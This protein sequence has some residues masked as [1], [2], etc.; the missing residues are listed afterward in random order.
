[1]ATCPPG[2]CE[3]PSGGGGVRSWQINARTCYACE[4]CQPLDPAWRG[5]ASPADAATPTLFPAMCAS[6]SLAER[7]ATPQKLRVAELRAALRGAQGSLRPPGRAGRLLGRCSH[8]KG[9]AA[10]STG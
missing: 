3:E 6:E 2:R 8:A 9:A 1:M 7:L 5:V 10:F 4:R